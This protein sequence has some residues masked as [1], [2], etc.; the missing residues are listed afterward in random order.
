MHEASLAPAGRELATSTAR[1]HGAE[2]ITSIRLVVGAL[3]EVDPD[4]LS[5][6]V[7]ALAEGGPAAG[8][9]VEVTEVA[10]E[11]ACARCERTYRVSPPHWSLR[12]E[13][14]GG[15]GELTAGR[16]LSVA[17]IEVE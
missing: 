16:E 10:A 11:A 8:A 1:E 3:A 5:F 4:S 15:V 12:C 9:V 2:R 6:W 14:C 7:E 17:S 13:R